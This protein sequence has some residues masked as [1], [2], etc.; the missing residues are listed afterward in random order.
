MMASDTLK[1]RIAI[2][3]IVSSVKAEHRSNIVVIFA[4]SIRWTT[5]RDSD[6]LRSL[7]I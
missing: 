1:M 7:E 2:L 5:W 6:E 4:T 3:K